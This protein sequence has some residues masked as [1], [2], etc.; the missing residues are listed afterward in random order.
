[1]TWLS[2]KNNMWSDLKE[3]ETI[4]LRSFLGK[5]H[6]YHLGRF[7]LFYSHRATKK[8]Q[9]FPKGITTFL[10]FII[11]LTLLFN[12]QNEKIISIFHITKV[13]R[14]FWRILGRSPLKRQ[15]QQSHGQ[16]SAHSQSA[17]STALSTV[18][19]Q[20][21][22]WALAQDLMAELK[23]RILKQCSWRFRTAIW[24]SN[25][26]KTLWG[27]KHGWSIFWTK[28]YPWTHMRFLIKNGVC[29]SCW[30]CLS[31]LLAKM[32]LKI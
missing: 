17:C 30:C 20:T 2:E 24:I 29:L 27:P 25:R 26:K 28:A 4:N 18:V 19:K 3:E 8:G 15:C 11:F 14:H 23:S 5:A 21:R 9:C 12:I 16:A 6:K 22:F 7:P 1:M 31:Q 10:Y 13:L 32:S